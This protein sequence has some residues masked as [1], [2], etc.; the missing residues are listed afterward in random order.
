MRKRLI[1][2]LGGLPPLEE[3]LYLLKEETRNSIMI[4]GHF[5]SEEE[6][7]AVLSG[8]GAITRDEEVA[9]HYF[10]IALFVYGLAYENYKTGEFIF[11]ESLIRQIN[12]GVLGERGEY[13]KGEIRIAG[14]RLRPPSPFH[15]EKWMKLYVDWVKENA[16]SGDFTDF[17]AKEH[18]LFESIHPFP[19]GNGRTGRVILNY[20]LISRGYP[21][22][23]IKGDEE[24]RKRYIRALEVAEEPLVELFQKEPDR[25]ELEK[26]MNEMNAELMKELIEEALIRSMDTI[27]AP[28]LEKKR[29]I[30]L[31]PSS[32]VASELGYS[33][34]SIRE[35]IRRGYFIAIK[36]GKSWFTHPSLDVRESKFPRLG[37]ENLE[38]PTEEDHESGEWFTPER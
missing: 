3:W 1:E 8:K 25:R 27:L 17:L 16:G 21:P 5:V 32:E 31:M 9:L 33:P 20:L 23:V 7:E 28:L 30:T 38:N 14:A 15:L 35:L 18:V 4:E 26:A 2:E 11:S 13:R 29:S 36:R 22:V 10:K 24:N 34:D 6:M 12:K 37:L 19:D